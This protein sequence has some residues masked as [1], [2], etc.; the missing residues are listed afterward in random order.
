MLV[1][2]AGYGQALDLKHLD[3]LADKASS[4]TEVTLDGS[5]LKLAAKFL[6]G[7]DPDEVKI[8]KL[9]SGL[10]GIYVKTFEFEKEGEYSPSDVTAIRK[11]LDSGWSRIVDVQSK[12]DGDNAEIYLKTGGP[13]G[14]LA[15]ICA[16]A[17]ELTIVNIVGKIDLD[18][19]SELGGNMGVPKIDVEKVKPPKKD[20]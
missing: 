11:Q 16:G 5:V 2:A 9:V 17:K 4:K 6:S 10:K 13:D 7:D 12:K 19:L 1:G 8:K 20:D 15:I 14:G 3:K 18:E